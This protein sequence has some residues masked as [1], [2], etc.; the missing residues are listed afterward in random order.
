L[1]QNVLVKENYLYVNDLYASPLRER[2]FALIFGQT[3]C[4]KNND[5]L[6]M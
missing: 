3:F 2:E 6:A 1:S 4:V 5:I